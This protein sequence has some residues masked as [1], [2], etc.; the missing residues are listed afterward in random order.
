MSHTITQTRR[1][2]PMWVYEKNYVCLARL[3]PFLFDRTGL[4]R[5][6]A[7]HLNNKLEISILEQ[8]RYTQVVEIK[9]IFNKA[10]QYL[11]G[12]SMKVRI[13]HDAQLAEVIS[14]QGLSKPKNVSSG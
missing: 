5:V 1:N 11:Q 2:S 12:L 6:C 13:Y 8:C 7:R 9:Q 14:Y 10:T 3:L 4:A